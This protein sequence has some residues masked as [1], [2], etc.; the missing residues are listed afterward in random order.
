MTGDT[1]RRTKYLSATASCALV[2]IDGLDIELDPIQIG[3]A[4]NAYWLIACHE[5]QNT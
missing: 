2:L 1:R 3:P 5:M 4:S